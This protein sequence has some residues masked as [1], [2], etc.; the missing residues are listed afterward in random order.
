[1]TL[2]FTHPGAIL[3]HELCNFTS[4]VLIS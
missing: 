1:M 2:R 4:S 3:E